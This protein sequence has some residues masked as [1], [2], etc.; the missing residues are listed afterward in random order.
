MIKNL[1]W[2]AGASRLQYKYFGDAIT[3]DTTYK[4]ILYDMPFG[5][6][7]GVNNHFRSVLLAGVMVHEEHVDS[8]EWVFSQFICM[9]G[10]TLPRKILAGTYF[11]AMTFSLNGSCSE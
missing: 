4:T 2:T 5:L 11:T 9:M 10:G 6:F 3:F 7:V 1:M 8:F